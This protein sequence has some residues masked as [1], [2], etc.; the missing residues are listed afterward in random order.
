[1]N[2][3]ELADA[4]LRRRPALKIL[5]TSGYSSRS[6]SPPAIRRAR[7]SITAGLL[8]ASICL[9]SLTARSSLRGW[10]E[11]R[12]PDRPALPT[13]TASPRN[14]S[15]H[16]S[17]AVVRKSL[18]CADA[19]LRQPAGGANLGI[20]G[21][22]RRDHAFRSR[23]RSATAVTRVVPA[24]SYLIAVTAAPSRFIASS[25]PCSVWFGRPG[26]TMPRRFTSAK[27]ARRHAGE[28]MP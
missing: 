14:D 7:S 8:Q 13:S 20:A 15:N 17:A 19:P 25:Q 9:Q 3:R 4:A 12:S 18:Q 2:G 16:Q 24:L 11:K 5:F 1:M 28:S 10:S 21:A 26:S 23:S 6:F 27:S 22:E